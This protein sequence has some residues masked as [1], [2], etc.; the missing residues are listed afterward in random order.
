M[1]VLTSVS[2]FVLVERGVWGCEGREFLLEG[3]AVCTCNEILELF[4]V[5]PFECRST[6]LSWY[7]ISG[8]GL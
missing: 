3:G 1:G 6:L 5:L 2:S 7:L 8:G 4:E